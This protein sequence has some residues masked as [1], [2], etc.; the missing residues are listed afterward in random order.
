MVVPLSLKTKLGTPLLE[1]T[2]DWYRD[3]FNLVVL[4]EWS[5]AVDRGCILGFAGAADCAY[6]EISHCEKRHD[7]TCLSLQ[8]RVED[9]GALVV[10]DEKRFAHRGPVNRPWGSRYL[11]FSDPNGVSVVVY[12]GASL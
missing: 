9:V 1:Q 12:S 11:Y 10:P 6:L 3:L 8:F 2:R 4:E 7:Y 5:D